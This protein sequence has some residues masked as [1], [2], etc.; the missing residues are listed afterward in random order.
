MTIIRK[1]RGLW[2]AAILMCVP[3][4]CN[5]RSEYVAPPPPAVTVAQPEIRDVTEYY[6]FTGTT[7]ASESVAIRAR[8]Q[9]FLN[10]VNFE[11]GVFVEEGDLLFVIDPQPFEARLKRAEADL[12]SSKAQLQLAE[13]DHRRIERLH[14]ED[15]AAEFELVKARS[16]WEA[17]EAAVLAAQAAVDEAQLNLGY[18]RIH[19]PISGRISRTLVDEGNLVGA[20]E[21]TLLTTIVKDDP[22]YA[23][24]SASE[25]EL[26]EYLEMHPEKRV[27]R[28]DQEHSP[29]YLGLP[30]ESGHPHPGYADWA[31]NRVDANTGTI[32]IR[33]V[34][35]NLEHVLLPGLFVRIRVPGEVRE[36]ARLI[37]EVALG[38]DQGGRY[39]F[40]VNEQNVVEKRY[41]VVGSLVDG[42]RVIEQGL[43]TEDRV[44]VKGIQRAREGLMVNPVRLEIPPPD[45]NP[46]PGT[47]PPPEQAG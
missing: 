28:A 18:T 39:L 37:T 40:L 19:A 16:D 45:G 5:R 35:A 34:F 38:A 43:A 27:P 36:N 30:N 14:G 20:G 42:M 21:Y 32:R 22:I 12:A 4:A 46:P 29:L 33:G 41:V 17:A 8:V 23:Y 6:D 7:E 2:A 11:A 31:D 10:S 13:Y 26:L 24:F 44:I 3:G 15:S 1:P 47:G 25:R 9:G